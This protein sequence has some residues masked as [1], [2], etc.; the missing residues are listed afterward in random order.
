LRERL[1]TV[2]ENLPGINEG[3]LEKGKKEV[4]RRENYVTAPGDTN[5]SDATE[6]KFQ[7]SLRHV[8]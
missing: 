8:K 7:K 5:P 4:F 3:F 1:K 2:I 6:T